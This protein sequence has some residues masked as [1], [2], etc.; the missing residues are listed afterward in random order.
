[1]C[2]V[3]VDEKCKNRNISIN[4]IEHGIVNIDL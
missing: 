2:V 4:A 1:M 3:S